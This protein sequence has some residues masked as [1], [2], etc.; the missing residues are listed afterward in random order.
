MA[1]YE[2][3]RKFVQRMFALANVTPD[4]V[5]NPKVEFGE[6][7]GID[8]LCLLGKRKIGVQVTEYNPDH[9]LPKSPAKS[10]RALEISLA[11]KKSGGFGFSVSGEY[12]TALAQSLKTKLTKTFSSVDEGWLL[13]VAQNPDYG[14]TSSTFVAA[15]HVSVE[16]MN[17]KLHP[18]LAGKHFARA[19]L[20]LALEG[21]LFE[22]C[23]QKRWQV[24]ADTRQPLDPDRV[25]AARQKLRFLNRARDTA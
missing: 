3:E 10:S 8:V 19:F 7:V 6:E 4:R 25:K 21:V 15:D 24:R 17:S 5:A 13:I 20:L 16:R 12:I 18:L 1:S 11:K 9:G 14:S 22:W 2:Q 23:P